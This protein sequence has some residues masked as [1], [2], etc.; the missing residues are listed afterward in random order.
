LQI[1][2]KSRVPVA[3]NTVPGIHVW[4][5]RAIRQRLKTM[6]LDWDWP[7]FRPASAMSQ[8][9]DPPKVEV[10][11]GNLA[12]HPLTR[13]QK[14]RQKIESFRHAQERNPN[15]PRACNN[16]AW[17]YLTA[18]EGLRDNKVALQLAEKAVQLAGKQ[19]EY[20]NTLGL[21]YYRAGKYRE[22]IMTL[23]PSIPTEDD[24]FLAYEILACDTHML[25]PWTLSTRQPAF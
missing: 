1:C 15:D 4:D 19:P 21:A 11:L 6:G 22:A 13:E 10:L 24:A 9:T 2:G 14:A 3:A 23:R 8:S 5:L 18:P 20:L 12:K 25:S 17:A 16:L 7:E